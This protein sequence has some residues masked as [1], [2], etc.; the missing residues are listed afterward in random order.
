MGLY[1][2]PDIFLCICWIVDSLKILLIFASD[3]TLF[4]RAGRRTRM[5][6]FPVRR[7]TTRDSW[8]SKP[9]RWE[10]RPIGVICLCEGKTG[11]YS[12]HRLRAV[13]PRT[14]MLKQKDTEIM[15]L[16]EEKVRLFR[17]M[18]EGLNPSEEASRQV[19]PYFR[20]ACSQEPPRGASIMKDALQE[21]KTELR[22]IYNAC[23]GE[24][25][26]ESSTMN[27]TDSL[28]LL[29]VHPFYWKF[30]HFDL[31][32]WSFCSL[33]EASVPPQISDTPPRSTV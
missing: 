8:R 31:V 11:Y 27:N 20:S 16:L 33:L 29:L 15:C 5:K 6:G 22:K 24:I 28:F 14:E 9:E 12:S 30:H 32:S 17:G 19:E 25:F 26:T 3:V 2:L 10:V 4:A 13:S 21:G 23:D 1:I 18:W 7:K